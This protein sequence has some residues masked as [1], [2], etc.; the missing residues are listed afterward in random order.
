MTRPNHIDLLYR[1]RGLGMTG[2]V[3]HI[4]A[5][6]DD[7]DIGLIAYLAHK[8][9]VRAVYWSATRGEGGQNRIGP[10]LGEALGIFRTWEA[11]AARAVDGGECLYGPFVDFGYSKH[12]LEGLDKWGH[13]E[14]VK[15]I[16]RAIRLVQPQII[17]S[18]WKGIPDDFH[19]HH[20]TVG[21]ATYEA[22]EAAGDA[23][24][25]PELL[26][27]GLAPWQPL[28]FYHSVNN[29]G[30]DQTLGGAA[31]VFGTFN[32]LF[33]REGV[34]RMNTGEFDPIAGMT[35]QEQ[36]W[37]AFSKHQ[38]Q[39]VAQAPAPGDFFYY[40][41]LYKS[42]VPTPSRETDMF[43]GLD[44]TLTALA[45]YPGNGSQPLRQKLALVKA[46]ASEALERFRAADPL[47]AS[48]PL[49]EGLTM[50]RELRAEVEKESFSA[51]VKLAL[52]SYLARKASDFEAVAAHCLGLKLEPLTN[53]GRVTPGQKFKLSVKLWNH[54]QLPDIQANFT[55]N[56]PEGWQIERSEMPDQLSALY[57]VTASPKATLSTPY[58]LT[59][60]REEYTYKWPTGMNG[61]PFGV[62]PLTVACQVTLG[63]HII[64]KHPCGINLQQE[65][66]F[67]EKFAGGYRE[68]PP[69]VIPPISL[70]PATTQEL[71][72]VREDKQKLKL[73][74]VARSHMEYTGVNGRLRLD[75][76]TGWQVSPES[77]D[78]SLG[79]VGDAR[80]LGFT[81]TL[82]ENTP[83]GDY[84][85]Q[86]VV[87]VEGRDY[88]A[89]F[90]AVRMAT[91]G[92]P[93]LPDESN[94][95]KEEFIITPAVVNVRMLNVKFVP[96]LRYAYI[97]GA[98]DDIPEV[99]TR[100]GL[101]LDLIEDHEMGYIDLNQFDAVIVGPNGYLVRDELRK[102]AT[103]FLSYVEQ[104]G[105]LIVQY[106]R[107]GYQGKGFAPYPFRYNQ[108]HDRV[109]FEEEPSPAILKPDHFSMNQPN[110]ITLA[111]FY[112]WEQDV[113]LYFF[114][115]WD[116]HYEPLVAC[117]D[118]GE[119]AKKGGML[120]A[121]YGRGIYLY[122]GYS[123]FRQLP[124]G[125]PGAFRLFA[126]LLAIP[127]TNLFTRAEIFKKLPLSSFMNDEQIYE[128]ARITA[129]RWEEDGT[130]LYR[131]GDESQ[132]MYLI[133]QGE[134]EIIRE[135]NG[136]SK[137]LIAKEGEMIGEMEVIGNLPRIATTRTR[138]DVRLLVIQNRAFRT[139]MRQHPD[140]SERVMQ[141][142]VN[143]M[144]AMV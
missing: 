48:S 125:V 113:G 92:L 93:G 115:E 24:Q 82:P 27:E 40:F 56:A 76:P 128:I 41:S 29:S 74:V 109:T 14:V 111:D 31:N 75:V 60:A 141:M 139:L 71:L 37:M 12:A 101:Q 66:Y 110:V 100:F 123:F 116:T 30:G 89:V 138:G 122:T 69:A 121:N 67:R 108:P 81:V 142:L 6:P 61:E 96:G 129:S 2:A 55:I 22:F 1:L 65:A 39:G 13:R 79:K 119:E 102:N 64:A 72:Q 86:Y 32:P 120:I 36:A 80:T 10:Y 140:I 95:V 97:R 133:T 11:E 88:D 19:G 103:R 57:D 91:P 51:H 8:F 46:K 50:L 3:L 9:G 94:C 130:Y 44:A 87:G 63:P 143:R 16:V 54:R 104:G 53:D 42:L 45:D 77:I 84:P 52:D 35:Y 17:V 78:L 18:R 33:E 43:D 23:E 34:L 21:K 107:Y 134:V 7:E 118:P 112:G 59:E 62:A 85:L 124:V 38:S 106:Q 28:K 117:H 126:N 4:G 135:S 58:W 137:V 98:T 26:A 73:Q 47:K 132:E 68:L 99:L 5:H 144:V 105:T 83:A 90:N 127:R 70:H 131:A 15:E 20:Q 114:G 25:F 49:L 136:D